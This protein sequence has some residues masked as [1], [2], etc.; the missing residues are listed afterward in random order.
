MISRFTVL[1]S[2][3]L[4]GGVAH[5]DYPERPVTII[6]PY[7]TGGPSDLLAREL[8]AHF[9]K[10]TGKAFVVENKPGAGGVIATTYVMRAAP[11]GYTLLLSSTS[12]QITLPEAMKKKPYDGDADFTPVGLIL[13][14]PFLLVGKPAGPNS[15]QELMGKGKKEELTWGSFGVGG[16]NHLVGSYFMQSQGFKGVHVPYKGS[17]A[18]TQALITGDLDFVFDSYLAVAGQVAAGKI[19]PLAVSTRTRMSVLPNVPTLQEAGMKSFD[20]SIWQAILGPRGLPPA[21]VQLL[22]TEINRFLADPKL[23]ERLQSQGATPLGGT[24]DEFRK[25]LQGDYARWHRFIADHH[26]R[27]ED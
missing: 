25:V 8:A 13:Q 11:D 20:E 1:L 9:Q 2:T 15:V 22:N 21:V 6:T 4:L 7:G 26:I 3:L 10:A 19:K 24:A 17:A 23:R 12:N 18:S 16:G 14:Y 27:I 5:A